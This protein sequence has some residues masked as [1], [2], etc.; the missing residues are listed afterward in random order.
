MALS[1][2]TLR[3]FLD[4]RGLKQ[5][6]LEAFG[7]DSEGEGV[8]IPY[9]DGAVKHRATLEKVD[10]KHRMWF[11]P[12]APEG[13]PIFMPPDPASEGKTKIVF[14]GETDTMAAWQ[15]AP[16]NVRPHLRGISGSNALGPRGLSDRIVQNEFGNYD[17]VFFVLDN[18][19]PYTLADKSVE[20][21]KQQIRARLGRKA[22]FVRLPLG[23]QDACEFFQTYDWAAFAELMK[24]AAEPVRH[25]RS[26]DLSK[27]PE[28]TD[29]L[30]EDLLVSK[31]TTVLASDAGVGKS[32]F[33]LALGLAVAGDDDTFLGLPLKK[34]GSVLIVDEEQSQEVVYERLNCLGMEQ[35]HWGNIEYLWYEGV[36]LANE[37]HK[38]LEQ[39]IDMEPALI[40]LESLSRVSLGIEENSNTEMSK[41]FRQGIIP[42]S[43]ETGAAVVVSHHTPSDNKGKPRGAGAIKAAADEAISMMEATRDDGSKTGVINIF[44]SKPRRE[45]ALLQMQIEGSMKNDKYVRVRPAGPPTL[46]F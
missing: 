25:Y 27:P 13:Q 16:S 30:V 24:Q 32:F 44:P 46:P 2:E 36:D 5:E 14:E 40:L 42:L 10:G 31:E 3:W 43:R 29:W 39:A 19:D 45:L 11:D 15:A 37:P 6:T 38:L 7:F 18:E 34:H 33:L 28:P 1:A 4:R 26:L 35:K 41:L 21:G 8:S 23:P 9:P 12:K 17:R 20:S 22:K